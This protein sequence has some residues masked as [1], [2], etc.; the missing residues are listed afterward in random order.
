MSE[1]RET[2][3]G[4]CSSRKRP[5]FWLKFLGG[6]SIPVC[7][8]KQKTRAKSCKNAM[9][10]T[11]KDPNHLI[12]PTELGIEK[13]KKRIETTWPKASCMIFELWVFAYEAHGLKHKPIGLMRSAPQTEKTQNMT[14]E[15]DPIHS[16]LES[17]IHPLSSG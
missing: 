12:L 14:K 1:N 9:K 5:K 2:G 13:K 4:L 3:H 16:T 17:I 11:T 6:C 15:E 8:L 7:T 10:L